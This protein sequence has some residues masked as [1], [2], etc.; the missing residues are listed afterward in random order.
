IAS[1]IVIASACVSADASVIAYCLFIM[2]I[3]GL[4]YGWPG[5]G[6][7]VGVGVVIWILCILFILAYSNTKKKLEEEAIGEDQQFFIVAG[8]SLLGVFLG[9]LGY[10]F[11]PQLHPDVWLG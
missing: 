6:V 7:G 3:L 1:A 4:K 8:T 10:Q 9:W 2:V 11:F 5:V